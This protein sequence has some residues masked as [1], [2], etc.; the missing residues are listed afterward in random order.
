ALVAELKLEPDEVDEWQR[1]AATMHVPYDARRGTHPP[2]ANFLLREVWDLE[3]PPA[4]RF[5]L[6]LHYHPL[7]I[8][9]HQVIKQADVVL[10]MFLLAD[11]F[12]EEQQRANFHYYD[13]LTPGDSSLS[14]CIQSIVA[15]ELGDEVRALDYFR[16][17]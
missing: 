8:Y 9:R 11:E 4:E 5:P 16:F 7:V 17:A 15:A 3:N 2:G 13:P 6:L 14:A 10:A 1:A 12:S